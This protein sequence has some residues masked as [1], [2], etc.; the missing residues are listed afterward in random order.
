MYIKVLNGII[1]KYPYSI[2]ELRKE[3]PQTSFPKRPSDELLAEWNVF[4]VL[5]GPSPFVD[6]TKNVVEGTP[7]NNNGWKQTWQVTEASASEVAERKASVETAAREQR[8][9]LLKE[10]DW[11]QVSD[12]PVDQS[13]WAEYRQSLRD[14][15]K[16]EG[17]PDSIS[18]PR[19]P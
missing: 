8:N 14:V 5:A 12:A 10:S 1:E 17:F 9:Y 13:A 3:N 6:Y 11:T 15:T 7:V 2:G 4:P 16:Q 19:V 18:W